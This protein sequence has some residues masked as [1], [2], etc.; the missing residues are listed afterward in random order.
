ME[1]PLKQYLRDFP[2]FTQNS[3]LDEQDIV[4]GV[5]TVDQ[6]GF[7]QRLRAVQ[8]KVGGGPIKLAKHILNTLMGPPPFGLESFRLPV[9]DSVA[10]PINN[11]RSGSHQNYAIRAFLEDLD[12]AAQ[13]AWKLHVVMSGPIEVL[14]SSEFKNAPI[15]FSRPEIRFISEVSNAFIVLCILLTYFAR[16]VR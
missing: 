4:G 6:S 11:L 12:A 10:P 13:E 14:T 9:L 1:P 16:F 5:K 2:N 7:P 15:V 3:G 8:P